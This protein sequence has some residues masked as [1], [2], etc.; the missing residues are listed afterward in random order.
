ML[1]RT[2]TRE[3]NVLC[4]PLTRDLTTGEVTLKTEMHN[5]SNIMATQYKDKQTSQY[6]EW[7]TRYQNIP[8]KGLMYSKNIE[9]KIV[10]KD[11]SCSKLSYYTV[12][13]ASNF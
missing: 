5:F 7:N 10:G 1:K 4:P 2:N 13:D 6:H 9:Q 8:Q 3:V 12:G 11:L